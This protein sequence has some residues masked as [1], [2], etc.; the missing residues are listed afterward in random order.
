MDNETLCFFLIESFMALKMLTFC[1]ACFFC[2]VFLV[3]SL[4]KF[5]FVVLALGVAEVRH[6]N[7]LFIYLHL[8]QLL[9][10]TPLIHAK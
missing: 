9:C 5:T 3:G 4:D 1:L 10:S 7:H 6:L 8:F 2:F